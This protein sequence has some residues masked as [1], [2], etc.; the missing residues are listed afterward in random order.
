M[1][2]HEC[3]HSGL[4]GGHVDN[5]RSI[6]TGVFTEYSRAHKGTLISYIYQVDPP[7]KFIHEVFEQMELSVKNIL[8]QLFDIYESIYMYTAAKV[9]MERDDDAEQR[10]VEAEVYFRSDD[11]KLLN[12]SE[13]EKTILECADE[14]SDKINEF[15]FRGSGWRVK[16]IDH[17]E[18][19]VADLKY[20]SS[21][22][23]G[24]YLQM[25]L[26]RRGFV[27]FKNMDTK[28]FHYCIVAALHWNELEP[29][30]RRNHN[31]WKPYLPLYD[32]SDLENGTVDVHRDIDEFE[33]KNSINVNVFSNREKHVIPIRRSR[34][35]NKTVVN[36]F[37]INE[38]RNGQQLSH[39]VLITDL[40]KFLSNQNTRK[41]YFCQYCF[42]EFK[43]ERAQ[44]LHMS[45]CNGE[46]YIQDEEFPEDWQRLQFNRPE[47]TLPFPYIC[48]YD[49]ETF[50]VPISEEDRQRGRS[51]RLNV[52][53]KAASYSIVIVRQGIRRCRVMACE[54]YDGP[55]V[56]NHFFERLFEWGQRLINQIRIT[57]NSLVPSADVLERHRKA[58]CCLFCGKTFSK[59]E[60]NRARTS[61]EAMQDW[62]DDY[63]SD[64]VGRKK[65][66]I[67]KTFH[68]NHH[69]G[70]YE[71][72]LCQVC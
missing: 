27:N 52:E 59:P 3:E 65:K 68:H 37:L 32:F 31:N 4:R 16:S 5:G 19:K 2:W 72:A 17:V 49:F 33:Q 45:H 11:H 10:P 25:P 7:T 70:Q 67:I 42:R 57:N 1:N 46:E 62:E 43:Q 23:A 26:L 55:D 36:L 9:T 21:A 58:E 38:Q 71:E 39:F 24:G 30:K 29:N 51:T 44:I 41:M 47:M 14:L 64:Q 53:Y 63:W 40:D 13:I 34:A 66:R 60:P 22:R 18:M 35:Q 54:Y 50:S 56:L 20:F 6:D 61:M 8:T 15:V 48:Y 12:T 28:C 69:T